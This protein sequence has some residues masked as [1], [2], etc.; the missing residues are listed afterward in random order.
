MNVQERWLPVLAATMLA[1]AAGGAEPESAMLGRQTQ[2][3][4]VTAL[5]VKEPVRVDGKLDEWDLT[6]EIWSFADVEVRDNFSVRSAAMWDADNLY[7]SFRWRDPMPLN[8]SVDP[9]FDHRNGWRA[10]A[11]Q[12]RCQAG[13]QVSWITV[14]EFQGKANFHIDYW[15]FKDK[16]GKM[17]EKLYKG[18]VG[19]AEL[20]DGIESSYRKLE[21]GAG[22][23]HELKIPWQVMFR[24]DRKM[25]VGD[26]IKL[27]MEFIWGDV[28][29]KAWPLHRYV[30]NMARGE[31]K[32]EFYWSSVGA[33]GELLLGASGSAKP[34]SYVAASSRLPGV[35]PVRAEIP[36]DAENFTLVL[37]DEGGNRVRNLAGAFA[38]SDF[39]VANHEGTRTVEVQWDGLDDYGKLVKPGIYRVRGLTAGK[40]GADYV[41]SFYSPGTPPWAT[42]DGK[43]GWA[44]DHT[45]PEFLARSGDR[46]VISCRVVEG[47]VGL[48]AVGP[49]GKKLWSAQRATN[50]MTANDQYV[51]TDPNHW[52]DRNRYLMR[53]DARTGKYAPFTLNGKERPLPLP[54]KELLGDDRYTRVLAA[55]PRDFMAVLNTGTLALFD[56]ESAELKREFPVKVQGFQ[57]G[58]IARDASSGLPKAPDGDERIPLA[59]NGEE[60]FFFVGNQLTALKVADG[61]CRT[62]ALDPAPQLPTALALDDDGNLVL[63][64]QGPDMQLKKYDRNGRLLARYGRRGGRARMGEFDRDAMREM[65][66]VAVGHDGR[67]W[68]AE[69]TDFPRRV[70]VWG[71]DG[72]LS[73][74]YV[75]NTGYAGSGGF[76]H[77]TEAG[78]AFFGPNEM[79]L[80]FDRLSWWM[81]RVLWNPE[82]GSGLTFTLDPST[83]A[84]GHIFKSKASG[85]EREYY[86]VPPY[87][88]W[89]GHRLLMK[90]DQGAWRPVAAIVPVGQ[91][92]GILGQHG[93]VTGEVLPEFT[94]C[95]P[96]DV[97]I[98]SDRNGDG[99]VQRAECEIVPARKATTA[100]RIGVPGVPLE[101]GWGQRMDAAT[102]AIFGSDD[103]GVGRYL[104][105][106]FLPDGAPVYGKA[107]FKYLAGIRGREVV[108]VPGE[109]E[110]IVSVTPPGE[111]VRY[112]GLNPET[113]KINWS[114]PSFYHGVH[115]SHRATMPKPGLLIGPLKVAGVVSDC[116][117]GG[118]VFMLRGNLGQDFYLT[119]DGLFVGSMFRDCRLPGAV[120]PAS[121][122]QLRKMPYELFTMGSEPFNGW[123]GRQDDGVVRLTCGNAGTASTVLTVR[124]LDSIRRFTAPAIT[125]DAAR[126][127]EADRDNAARLAARTR[128]EPYT[129]VRSESKPDWN[130]I[131]AL[132][133]VR[134]GQ[135][136]TGECRLAW[137]DRTLYARFVVRDPSPWKNGGVDF[138]Q[139]FKTGDCVDL[140]LSPS[141]NSGRNPV[142]G[143]FRLL[144]APFNGR[145]TAVLMKPVAKGAPESERAHYQSPVTTMVFDQVKIVPEAKIQ[146]RRGASDYTVELEVP[147]TAL[148]VTVKAGQKL[149]GD[150]GFILSDESGMIN[151]ARVYYANF[152]TNLVSDLP[153][154]SKLSPNRWTELTL[155]P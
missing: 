46:M 53:F 150:A 136:V 140:Q 90:N 76:L 10:D 20:G 133:I 97:A 125:V 30:D 63:A 112:V 78:R 130:R 147:W 50:A 117:E 38:A 127:V 11:V 2:N 34:R 35:I 153:M 64:D 41:M 92:S 15:E 1:L 59:Y 36:A 98:W 66:S 54:Q 12:L 83:H 24:A 6:G 128:V 42:P 65:S 56:G 129:V 27:G 107:G 121:E 72:K 22:F 116:G 139:L 14:W 88:Y 73:R 5:P 105:T 3:E 102:L 75:G 55:G 109:N 87:Y 85:R 118:N 95:D 79:K 124:G 148:G 99:R 49:D 29:G 77:D 74:E 28:T 104:P 51:Y 96:Y 62:I 137:N 86:Y 106:G 23:V 146:L 113:G 149:R 19:S 82:P 44:A 52:T 115:G 135:P 40:L 57:P 26:K 142:A 48:F 71:K 21:D 68:T 119:S 101:G 141:A 94:G 91:L 84:M 138:R 13:D 131:P 4:G 89:I 60:A 155:A 16:P 111:A 144:V 58:I 17:V 32:R 31:T 47:G 108:P 132:K 8:S 152:D 37:E 114:Y 9:D 126:L 18:K 120:L 69:Y 25:R 93:K 123:I 134:E 103:Q 61:S 110:L 122:E 43:G 145:P 7:L 154:E 143:D 67:V 39:T 45:R 100:R 70:S 81:T 80:D 151:T 33:W